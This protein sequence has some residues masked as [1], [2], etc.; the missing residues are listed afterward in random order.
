MKII[1]LDDSLTVQ[2]ILESLLEDLGVDEH[3]IYTFDDGNLALEF[4]ENEGANIIFSDVN[5]PKMHG[6]EFVK[7]VLNINPLF[8]STLFV[9][10]ADNEKSDLVEMKQA[11]AHRFIQK[12][13][14]SNIFSHF[15]VPELLK[16]RAQEALI[17]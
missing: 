15:I 8:V 16:I 17:D 12:P 2:M 3:E 1:I 11:G 10:S 14:D 5:M 9:I 7:K 13:I 4:I 6:R